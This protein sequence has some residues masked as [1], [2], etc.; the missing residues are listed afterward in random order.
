MDLKIPNSSPEW[1]GYFQF[2]RQTDNEYK[3]KTDEMLL[4]DH[5]HIY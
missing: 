1:I 3:F 4:I 5:K 2:I